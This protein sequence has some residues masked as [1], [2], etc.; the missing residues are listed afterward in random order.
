MNNETKCEC[1]L[2][3]VLVSYG[4]ASTMECPKCDYEP[5]DIKPVNP[6]GSYSD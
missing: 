3:L 2:Y 6:A 4:I 1:G 5:K